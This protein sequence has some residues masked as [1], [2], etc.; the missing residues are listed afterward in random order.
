MV[1]GAKVCE[2]TGGF[3]RFICALNMEILMSPLTN[4]T[5]SPAKHCLGSDCRK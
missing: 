2:L 1:V 3:L 5:I 4:W